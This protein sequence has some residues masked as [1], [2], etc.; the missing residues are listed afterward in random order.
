MQHILLGFVPTPCCRTHRGGWTFATL[1]DGNMGL[2]QYQGAV[3]LGPG[4]LVAF[5]DF[6]QGHLQWGAQLFELDLGLQLLAL[7]LAVLGHCFRSLPGWRGG[8]G[9]ATTLGGLA[10]TVLFEMLAGLIYTGRNIPE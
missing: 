3:R 10:Y 7:V 6:C 8:Q 5:I 1:G 4:I 9:L 2:R